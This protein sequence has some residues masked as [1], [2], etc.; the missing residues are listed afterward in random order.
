VGA[1]SKIDRLIELGLSRYGAGDLEG[2]LLVWEEAL[3]IDPQNAQANSYVD[4]VRLHFEMLRGEPEVASTEAAPFGIEE[5]PEYQI[6]ITDGD[7][8]LRESQPVLESAEIDAGWFDDE[9]A[10][11][12]AAQ[13]MA[14]VPSGEPEALELEAELP[15]LELEA[16]L[17]EALELE[18]ELPPGVDLPPEV[19]LP[20]EAPRV[21]TRRGSDSDVGF[22]DA[23][24]EYFGGGGGPAPV[25][26][27]DFA[28][29]GATNAGTSEVQQE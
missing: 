25:K 10:T 4:Y 18:A 15:E 1:P 8:P 21:E 13:R 17:P 3:A 27:S 12:D 26:A 6:E 20:P 11:H 28:D 9:V 14:T 23:T 24:R 22:D 19:E 16:E 5:E 7:L 2:A 29:S